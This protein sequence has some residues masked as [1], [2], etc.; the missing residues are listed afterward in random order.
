MILYSS[1]YHGII[2][3]LQS[4]RFLPIHV[5][6]QNGVTLMKHAIPRTIKKW[7]L[8]LTTSHAYLIHSKRVQKT[9]KKI[10]K[11]GKKK[12]PKCLTLQINVPF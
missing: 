6:V 8:D 2:V 5:H 12:L 9:A 1:F 7:E 4:K 3:V 11:E 10:A